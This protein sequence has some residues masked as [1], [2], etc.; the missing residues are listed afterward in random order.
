MAPDG[1][2]RIIF[3][4]DKYIGEIPVVELKDRIRMSGS[5]GTATE[6]EEEY[7]GKGY[8]KKAHLALA[9]IAKSEGKTLYS[10]SSN[11]D[12]EDALWK[13]LVKDGIAE[14]VSESP[15]DEHWHHTTYRIINDK[16]PQADDI[17]SG[18]RGVSKVVDE[19]GE[20]LIVWH[21]GTDTYS[22]FNLDKSPNGFYFG[23]QEQAFARADM[24]EDYVPNGMLIQ[25][26]LNIRNPKI[27]TFDDRDINKYKAT[28]DGFIIKVS[29]EDAKELASIGNC[30]PNNFKVQYVAFNPN[31][32]KSATDNNGSFS[33]IDNNIYNY[34]Q[35]GGDDHFYKNASIT[36]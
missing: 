29:E 26:F 6:I 18:D 9:N 10:D 16:L 33:S 25:T 8:G 11:S 15:K 30:N 12:A 20:P 4:G 27:T 13:S 14:V 3:L 32:I 28:N 2:T 23:T 22:V 17:N 31:Q 36:D 19:N 24:E 35:I 5:I 34:I 1:G 7:R 21:F